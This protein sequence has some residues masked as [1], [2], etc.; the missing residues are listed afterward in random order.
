MFNVMPVGEFQ[1]G[2]FCEVTAQLTV[3]SLPNHI[4]HHRG[5]VVSQK[6]SRQD[7]Q[8]FMSAALVATGG[9]SRG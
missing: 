1:K 5:A 6:S 4:T 7:E 2:A 9:V 3:G 8:A